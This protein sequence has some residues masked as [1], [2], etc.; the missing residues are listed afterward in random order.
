[1]TAPMN[2][3]RRLYHVNIRTDRVD[4]SVA[5]YQ[6]LLGLTPTTPPDMPPDIQVTW[7]CDSSGLPVIHI[8]GPLRGEQ[9]LP[10]QHTGRLHH[11]AFD[12]HGYDAIVQ[13]LGE[14]NLAYDINVV[15]SVGLRQIFAID[16]N[17]LRV[18]LNFTAD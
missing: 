7:L 2:H 18:E 5:F 16:P 17:G 12:C 3:V 1:M 9:P 4:D 6:R 13:R 15:A 10:A 8:T 11:V 14:M